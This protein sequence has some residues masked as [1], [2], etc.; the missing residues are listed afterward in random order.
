MMEISKSVL[1]TRQ[2][3]SEGL[4][5]M[6]TATNRAAREVGDAYLGSIASSATGPEQMVAGTIREATAQR[7]KDASAT[8]AQRIALQALAGGLSGPAGVALA[9]VGLQVLEAV[10]NSKDAAAMAGTLLSRM[11]PGGARGTTDIVAET[12]KIAGTNCLDSAAATEV[13]KDGLRTLETAGS[14]RVE[15]SLA[16]FGLAA[17]QHGGQGDSQAMA[18]IVMQQIEKYTTDDD[19]RGMA[20]KAFEDAARPRSGLWGDPLGSGSS[21]NSML[22]SRLED[23]LEA[24]VRLDEQAAAARAEEL[25]KMAGADPRATEAGHIEIKDDTVVIGGVRV[26]KNPRPA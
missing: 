17:R 2:Y 14:E 18:Q 7:V 24:A 5:Q 19:I 15:A 8:T 13:F 23:V 20:H 6:G 16:R 10:S 26:N 9:R 21:V 25:A 3:A 11:D 12:V 4:R 1:S 22:G